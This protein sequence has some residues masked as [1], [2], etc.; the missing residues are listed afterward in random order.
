[1]KIFKNPKII[2]VLVTMFLNFLGFSIIIPV[3]PFLVGKYINDPNL[4]AWNVGL[5]LSIFAFCQFFAAPV[6]GALSDRYGRRP[7]L[8]VSLL[9][10]VIGY[11]I[12]GIGGSIWILFLGR[13]IDGTTGGNI[14]TI[15]SYLADIT[16]PKDRG[17]YYG[18]LGAAGG[19]G[20]IVGPALGGLFAH[21]SVSAPLF[22]AALVTFINMLWGYFILP[23]S[24]AKEHRS[25]I[26]KL[27]HLNPFSQFSHVFSSQLLRRIFLFGFIFLFSIYCTYGNNAV[28][29]KDVFNWGPTQIGFLLFIVGIV[30]VF[31]QGFLVRKLM[32]V[33]HEAKIAIIGILLVLVGFIMVV[34]TAEISSVIL[35]YAAIVV[36]NIGDGLF[37]PSYN[38]LVSKSVGPEMQGRVQGAN[39]GMQSVGRVIAPLFSAWVYGY[40]RGLP[41]ILESIFIIIALFVLIY[42]LPLIRAFKV[43]E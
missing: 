36:Y 11:T 9:G 23:E 20:F 39:M 6:L 22:A 24:L 30:D 40:W 35:F 14:S 1:M 10:S 33:L 29:M 41:F 42:T 21:I 25:K 19:F 12:M 15:Y 26:I 43:R 27:T 13:I 4:I 28:F 2:F 37:E 38:S 5:I 8:L 32:P 18:M 17:K 16:E 3:I 7:I 34:I 31:S